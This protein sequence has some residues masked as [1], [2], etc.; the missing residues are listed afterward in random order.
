MSKG[1]NI[2]GQGK[3]GQGAVVARRGRERGVQVVGGTG[4]LS[5]SVGVAWLASVRWV[6]CQWWEGGQGSGEPFVPVIRQIGCSQAARE[7]VGY[8]VV[9]GRRVWQGGSVQDMVLVEGIRC[10][11]GGVCWCVVVY[12]SLHQGEVEQW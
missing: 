2:L 9:F 11:E 1:L 12:Q 3:V 6:G 7:I 10:P 5:I 8:S 4:S